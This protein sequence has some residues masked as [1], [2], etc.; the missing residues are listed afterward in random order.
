M[1]YVQK[2][3]AP[4]S[5]ISKT[6]S[7]SKWSDYHDCCSRQKRALRKYI[8]KYEQNYLCIYCESKISSTN[9]SSHLEHIKPRH[10]DV[11]SL[12]F[13][14]NNIAVS[15]NGNC[16]NSSGD[17]TRYNC[18]HRKDR[19]DTPYDNDKFLNPVM[20]KD[21]RDYFKYDFDD[22]LISP[23]NKDVEKA[24]Y[25]IDTL[26]LNDGGLPKGREK[27]LE[28]FIKKMKK[29][30]NIDLRKKIMKEI[31]DKENIAFISFLKFKYKSLL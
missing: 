20:V 7:L 25:M 31:L 15:C 1:R 28:T 29:I 30:S 13:D 16:N 12:T 4:Q 5:F 17:N 9:E 3:D 19:D 6:N 23:S 8:L 18:G 27:A 10:L 2:L 22:Y 21:I 24:Q 26:H 11:E 14:Y